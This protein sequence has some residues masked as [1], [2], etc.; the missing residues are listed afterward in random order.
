[1]I[2]I[3]KEKTSTSNEGRNALLNGYFDHDSVT[4]NV[5]YIIQMLQNNI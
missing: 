3:G 4:K 2:S 5:S 1:M